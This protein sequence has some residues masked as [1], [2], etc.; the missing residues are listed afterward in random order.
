MRTLCLA[1]ILAVLLA[2][3]AAHAGKVAGNPTAGKALFAANNCGSCH[4]L[5]AAHA[6]GVIAWNLDKKKP[7][8]AAIVSA[9]TN[10]MTKGGLAM[11]AY[12]GTLSTKQIQDLAAFVY[13]A[14]HA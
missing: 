3:A 7:A 9:V 1:S 12:K 8:Y 5:A 14:T 11:T 13:T 10:G 6:T 4:T 2:P